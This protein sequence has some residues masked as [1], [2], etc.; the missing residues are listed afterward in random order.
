MIG[1]YYFPNELLIK[2]LNKLG[3][4]EIK[5]ILLINHNI[6][7]VVYSC[8]N[9]LNNPN[10]TIEM[11]RRN[12]R[13]RDMNGIMISRKMI[14]NII[15]K[16]RERQLYNALYLRINSLFPKQEPDDDIKLK[17]ELRLIPKS[18]YLSIIFRHPERTI[19]S[20]P[21]LIFYSSFNKSFTNNFFFE[22]IFTFEIS[23][24]NTFYNEMIGI[25]TLIFSIRTT[26]FLR[27]RTVRIYST[28]R[29]TESNEVHY[30]DLSS[31]NLYTGARKHTSKFKSSLGDI[32]IEV[33]KL[34][35][36]NNYNQIL[37]LLVRVKSEFIKKEINCKNTLF[38][39]LKDYLGNKD[40]F[41]NFL[42]GNLNSLYVTAGDIISI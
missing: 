34:D 12:I 9:L 20:E 23:Y 37:E 11:I 14:N 24:H 31:K 26:I 16:N 15:I 28:I 41:T 38:T 5:N 30:Y 40:I 2:I 42:F 19:T 1:L 36:N 21:K 18:E 25:D 7:N 33:P 27:F 6:F 8:L 32:E 3:F 29:I 10:L 17:H 4:E 22:K 13:S 39:R 35:V